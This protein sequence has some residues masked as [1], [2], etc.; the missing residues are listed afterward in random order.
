MKITM[1][2]KRPSKEGLYLLRYKDSVPYSVTVL[3]MPQ[4]NMRLK[5]FVYP[6]GDYVDKYKKASYT[7]SEI[8]EVE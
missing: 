8:I 1:T 5:V 4:E 3:P 6:D 2:H 7:W